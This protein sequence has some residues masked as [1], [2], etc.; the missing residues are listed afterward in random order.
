MALFDAN[1]IMEYTNGHDQ[2]EYEHD[3]LSTDK[4]KKAM[5]MK[6]HK[7]CTNHKVKLSTELVRPLTMVSGCPATFL[8]A[9]LCMLSMLKFSS[10]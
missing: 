8:M 6:V 9:P 3:P 4:A 2:Y 5:S 1:V 7:F 10:N